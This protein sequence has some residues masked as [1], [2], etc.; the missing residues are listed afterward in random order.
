MSLLRLAWASLVNRRLTASLAILA[1]AMSVA[2]LLSVEKI[3]R[4]ARTSFT[5]TVSDVD[6][7]VGARSGAIQLLLYSVFRIG[8]ATNNVSWES[9]AEIVERP[10]VRWAIPLSLGDSHRGFRVLGT[11]A[12]YFEHYRHGDGR[13]LRFASGGPSARPSAD[14]GADGDASAEAD[15]D[16]GPAGEPFADLFDAVLGSEV[17]RTLGYRLDDPIVVS[18]GTGR[19]AIVEHDDQ[20][21]RVAGVLAPT[22]TPVDRTV[23]V[24]LEGIEAMHADWGRGAPIPGQTTDPETLRT[25]QL[26]PRAVTAFLLGLDSPRSV[27]RVQRAINEYRDE[28]L[29]AVLPGVAL[30]E[31]WNL[32]GVA[33]RALLI[34]S[35][36]VVVAALVNLVSVLLAS[37]EERRREIAIL[38]ASGAR[39]AHVFA[40]LAAEAGL[41]GLGGILGGLALHYA[42]VV[43]GGFWLERRFGLVTSVGL[44]QAMDWIV[45]GA[46]LVCAVLVGCLPAWRAYRHSLADGMTI[47]A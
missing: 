29:L 32:V 8:D 1:I 46:I 23:H 20:P 22:G 13:A 6:L 5:S 24:S 41:L 26:E 4:D 7:V 34:V 27:L 37:L 25:M 45:L 18:H 15:A 14:R 40:L 39:P 33:E 17:A 42:C 35:S 12:A 10:D 21:F 19:V 43:V 30:R 11:N 28:P 16:A 36:F 44:P 47:R 31:L 2:L 3:R 9:Y 38:R